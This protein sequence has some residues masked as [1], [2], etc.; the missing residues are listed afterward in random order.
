MLQVVGSESVPPSAPQVLVAPAEQLGDL[1]DEVLGDQGHE[2]AAVVCSGLERSPEEGDGPAIRAHHR[3]R[4]AGPGL[5]VSRERELAQVGQRCRWH[6]GDDD[7]DG[8]KLAGQCWRQL[9]HRFLDET[10]EPPDVSGPVAVDR[11]PPSVGGRP[12]VAGVAVHLPSVG[13]VAADDG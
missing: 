1:L 11:A 5:P 9:P 3:A 10:C 2:I 6:L 8:T 13:G 12:A 4:T 7:L